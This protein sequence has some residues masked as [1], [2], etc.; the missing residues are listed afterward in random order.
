MSA[1]PPPP[2]PPPPPK[3][4]T[5]AKLVEE[6][7]DAPFQVFEKDGVNRVSFSSYE[8]GKAQL[9]LKTLI[10]AL[11]PSLS[12]GRSIP[13]TQ[14]WLNLGRLKSAALVLS[15]YNASLAK[16]DSFADSARYH[17]LQLFSTVG[18]QPQGDQLPVEVAGLD[19]LIETLY[20]LH[21]TEHALYQKQVEAGIVSFDGLADLFPPGSFVV[22]PTSLASGAVQ[23]TYRVSS[24]FFEER[25]TMLGGFERSFHLEL[26][27][28]VPL[29][30]HY[31]LVSFTEIF[32]GWTG[33]KE[34]NIRDLPVRP[35]SS[36]DLSAM[37]DRAN[38]TL[39]LLSQAKQP[40]AFL[41]YRNGA[42]FAHKQKRAGNLAPASGPG[43]IVLDG[44]K[45]ME[46]GHHPSQGSSEADLAL[47]NACGRYRRSFLH[48]ESASKLS[49]ARASAEG[50][51]LFDHADIPAELQALLWPAL[52]G[53][54]LATKSWGR[55]LI[56]SLQPIQFD[57]SA[58]DQLVLPEARK[59]LIRALV[60]FGG[61]ATQSRFRDIISSKTGGAVFLLHGP[62]GVGKTLTAEA[63]AELLH[64][65]LYYVT[66]GELGT[67]PEQMEATLGEVLDLCQGWDA[68]AIIDEADV[69]L[70]KRSTSEVVR[71]AMVCVMLRLIEYH[72]GILFLTT[73]RV[74]TLDPAFESR[75]TIALRYEPLAAEARKEIWINLTSH[76]VDISTLD[77]D[78]L[79]SYQLN[80]R[81]I[82]TA[83][84][85]ALAL[86]DESDLDLSQD[87]LMEA[88]HCADL[89][90]LEMQGASAF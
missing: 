33:A 21:A 87:L 27:T 8:Q 90:R 51:L 15:Q 63:I 71:N 59:R 37:Q 73:N 42:F 34:K 58:F 36:A 31:G 76:L 17:A 11:H 78:A 13:V 23:A 61:K 43:R 62:P 60:R 67:S 35:A 2:P 30:P 40:F 55:V 28:L 45:G 77:L 48:N 69:F 47:I 81:Q 39:T 46:L 22:A 52:V 66:M 83:V 44:A 3:K 5:P 80:G 65:P 29:G 14:L 16:Q 38:M 64:R 10:Q 85:L 1:A 9:T 75:V 56:E 50:M 12:L 6:N 86:A 70:E 72:P 89:G 18:Y 32:S 26:E 54:S 84:R 25:R 49:V 7:S 24:C 57:D 4:D 53:F 74:L 82:K 88:L 20:S 19:D 68:L 79:S 41:Q